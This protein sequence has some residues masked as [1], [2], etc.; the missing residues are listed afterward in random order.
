MN[1]CLVEWESEGLWGLVLGFGCVGAWSGL[2]DQTLVE[3]V[4]I[5][6]TFIVSI[7]EFEDMLNL[8]IS[9]SHPSINRS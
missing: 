2:F 5:V 6:Y 9:L 7:N 3:N 8:R 1:Q 4:F